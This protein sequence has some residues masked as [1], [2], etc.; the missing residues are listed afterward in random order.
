MKKIISILTAVVM[1]VALLLPLTASAASASAS[2]SG[3]GT[4]RAGD[5]ITVTFN[6]NGKGIYGASGTLAYDSSQ[7]SLTGTKQVIASPWAVEFNGNN[8]VA[9]DNNLSNPINSNKALFT[10]TF[11]VKSVAA[12]TNIKISCNNVAASDGN[13]DINIGSVSYSK[14]TSAARS[15]ENKL[16]ALNITNA[17]ISPAFSPDTTN[18]TANVPFSVS[19]L[20]ISATAK[21]SK[22]KVSIK[23]NSL[24]VGTTNVSVTV[25][26]ENGATKTYV[27]KVTREQDPN[28]VPSSNAELSNI[29][30]EGYVLSPVFDPAVTDY[31]VWLP[32]E[33]ESIKVTGKAADSK[34]SGVEVVGGDALIA[35]ED[36]IITITCTAEDGTTTKTYT[37]V[38]KRA[39]AH[40]AE[41]P[42]PEQP[43]ESDIQTGTDNAGAIAWWW[44]IIVAVVA[45]AAGGALGFVLG[46]KTGKAPEETTEE[47]PEEAPEETSEETSEEA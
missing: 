36:N 11:K 42:E 12:G 35:G 1:T 24:A 19:K 4:V 14:V 26:A 39:A 7:V 17:T 37:L 5:S 33:T 45:L 16:S 47:T 28:Y 27:I 13:A 23:N 2:M 32:Y 30:I 18:Y 3:P 21:D 10:A 41:T 38:A 31:V 15:G 20:A 8:F 25:T 43:I 34:A 9:Y 29:K 6:L 22:A 40:G 44:L 46:K